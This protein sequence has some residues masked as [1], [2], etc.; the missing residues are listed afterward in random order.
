[1]GVTFIEY[2]TKIRMD[3]A[4]EYLMCSNMKSSEIGYAV[5]YKDPHYF[6]FIF[7]KTQNMSPKEYRQRTKG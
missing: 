4:K 7:K 6:S 2:L 1:M 5:G 3:K